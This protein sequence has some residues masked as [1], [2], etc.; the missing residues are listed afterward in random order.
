[1]HMDIHEFASHQAGVRYTIDRLMEVIAGEDDYF[2][3]GKEKAYIQLH[4][5]LAGVVNVGF[6]P[7][8]EARLLK[9]IASDMYHYPRGYE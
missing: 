5:Y 6:F 8:S 1:M 4:A 2:H 9:A 7:T 3:E